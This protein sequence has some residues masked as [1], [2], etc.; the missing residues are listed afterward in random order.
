MPNRHQFPNGTKTTERETPIPVSLLAGGLAGTTVDLSLYPI[1]TVK[2][3]LQSPKGFFSSGGFRGI[4][5]GVGAAALGSAPGAA[6][7]FGVYERLKI[8]LSDVGRDSD[9]DDVDSGET[10]RVMVHMAAASI[11]GG[12]ACLIRVPTEVVKQ[13][14][15][16]AQHSSSTASSLLSTLRIILA[17][18]GGNSLFVP[19]FFG[20]LYR[21]YGVTLMREVPFALIQFPLYERMKAEWSI[22]QNTEVSPTQAAACGSFSGAIAAALTTPLDV[23]KTRLMIGKDKDGVIYKNAMDAAGRLLREEG[24]RKFLSGVEP[25]VVWISIGGFVY[26]GAYESIRTLTLPLMGYEQL[27]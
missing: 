1:D 23:I 24:W 20:G 14:M 27:Q 13:N 12:A 10:R 6:L 8:V 4:Y 7:F 11:G 5:N 15:Q 19:S 18:R 2:T 21:G 17:Q 3:R 16:I 26:F 25:R 9:D 22:Y